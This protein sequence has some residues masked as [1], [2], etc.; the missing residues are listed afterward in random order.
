MKRISFNMID[1]LDTVKGFVK[2]Y[3]PSY[4]DNEIEI[5]ENENNYTIYVTFDDT[6]VKIKE[7]EEC[8]MDIML[9]DSYLDAWNY[10]QENCEKL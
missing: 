2:T 7:L 5:I 6:N 10:I 4:D 3:L 1:D 9:L 8:F